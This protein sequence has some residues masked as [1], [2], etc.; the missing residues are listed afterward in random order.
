MESVISDELS[1][2]LLSNNLISDNQHGFLKNRS[3][4]TNLLSSTRHW[5]SSLNSR[6]S[7]DIIFI[8]FAKAFDSISH[9]KLLHKLKS[10]GI[11]GKLFN[12]ISAWLSN[13]SQTVLIDGI[14]SI[15]LAV[16]RGILQGSVLGL[17]L[18]ILFLN[19][20]VDGIPTE[21]HPTLFA[22]DL[23]I[24]SDEPTIPSQNYPG[25]SYSPLLQ[26]SLDLILAWTVD[27]QLNIS[28]S[29]CSILSIS[30]SK[31]PLGRSYT[32][33]SIVLPQ[34]T[35]CSDLGTIVDDKLSF[36]SHIAS[37]TKKAYC[38]S[39]L[40]SRC[41]V[42]KN[43]NLLKRSFTSYVRP[44]LEY[45][46]PIWSPYLLNLI[47]LVENVQRRFTKSIPNLRAM[48]YNRRLSFLGLDTLF[49][50][51]RQTNLFLLATKFYI[52][53]ILYNQIFFLTHRL[54]Y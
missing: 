14:L 39:K 27:W 37:I 32:L 9:P 33:N 47:T 23:K 41:F 2:Y 11:T 22:D 38:K 34:V 7:T 3:T 26:H 31:H 42:S 50:R 16:L 25:N 46:T 8:D 21:S 43:C 51:R 40:I 17:I 45:A 10:Y 48:S 52:P 28:F 29:K 5:F 44:L 15:P 13:R 1:N 49:L 18:F 6:K 53:S 4:L 36:S 54:Y 30:Y 19:D 12:W 20:I 24:F 35:S